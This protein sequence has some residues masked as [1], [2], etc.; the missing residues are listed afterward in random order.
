MSTAQVLHGHDLDHQTG[1]ARKVLG[2]LAGTRLGVVLLPCEARV[3]PGLVDGFDEVLAQ[4]RVQV[5]GLGLVGAFLLGGVLFGGWNHISPSCMF[6][7][8]FR[9]GRTEGNGRELT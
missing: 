2:A 5:S 6:F 9:F 4:A 3:D 7:F 8:S 1:P